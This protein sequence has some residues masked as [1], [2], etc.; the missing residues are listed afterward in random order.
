MSS[1]MGRADSAGDEQ[2]GQN[3]NYGAL[4]STAPDASGDYHV[5]PAQGCW[6]GIF[7]T[8]QNLFCEVNASGLKPNVSELAQH[9]PSCGCWA[10]AFCRQLVPKEKR[11]LLTRGTSN[12]NVKPRS[13]CVCDGGGW[14][15][16]LEQRSSFQVVV[17]DE[18]VQTS[19][20]GKTSKPQAKKANSKMILDQPD[21]STTTGTNSLARNIRRSVF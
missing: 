12:S 11:T 8:D 15:S 21:P 3:R 20:N 5:V 18:V 19:A 6:Y 2:A 9:M 13:H 1:C 16:S 7:G 10:G 14:F 4:A 17:H